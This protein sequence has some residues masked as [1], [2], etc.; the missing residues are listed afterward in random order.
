[1]DRDYWTKE[2]R[3]SEAEL[4]A[5]KRRTELN[6]EAKRLQRAKTELS[7]S[8]LQRPCGRSGA[9]TVV[10]AR[11]ALP[12]N[13]LGFVDLEPDCSRCSI[14]RMASICRA[15]SRACSLRIRRNSSRLRVIAKPIENASWSRNE[16]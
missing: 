10:R 12:H 15:L 2:L 13:L 7:G 14:T 9:L 16:R 6:A 5:A 8:R 1:M 11:R 3:E 4:A